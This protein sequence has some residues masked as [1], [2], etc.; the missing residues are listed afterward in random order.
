MGLAAVFNPCGIAML[1]ATLAWLVGTVAVPDRPLGMAARGVQAGLGMTVGFTAVVAVLALVVHSLGTIL[2]PLLRPAMLALGALLLVGG[3]L[4]AL[5]LFHLPID[6]WTRVDRWAGPGRPLRGGLVV[7]GVAYGLAALSCTLP[8]F[9]AA[10]VPA[11]SAGWPT[12]VLTVAAFGAGS[13]AVFVGVSEV[14]L[15][16]RQA[17]FHGVHRIVSWVNPALGAVVAAAGGYLLYYW[18]WGPGH[19]IG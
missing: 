1:P 10:L 8:L 12:A 15:F 17:V 4:V 7:A 11:M 13:G 18:L 16:A 5:G 19:W 14:T 9:V 2:T 6:Q 3:A